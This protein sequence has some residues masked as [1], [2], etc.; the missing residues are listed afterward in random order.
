MKRFKPAIVF[1]LLVFCTGTS[2]S[3]RPAIL[4]KV[5][6]LHRV[7]STASQLSPFNQDVE[8]VYDSIQAANDHIARLLS[9]ILSTPGIT[10]YD[11]DS[12]LDHPFLSIVKS[13]DK[14]VWIFNWYEIT[15]GSCSSNLSIIHYRT[16]SMMPKVGHSHDAGEME[17]AGDGFCANGASFN[18]VYKLPANGKDLYLCLGSGR[19]CNTCVYEIA[20]V[21][22]LTKDSIHF[23][24]PAFRYTAIDGTGKKEIAPCFILEAR[25]DNIEEFDYDAKTR[26]L[27]FKYITDDN[28]PV[29]SNV[30]KKIIRK[31]VFNEQRFVG[32]PYR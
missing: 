27:R 16:R 22:E 11:L 19:S 20:S 24:Y 9:E 18:R 15:V 25:W 2:F 31:L 21:V 10:K 3:Q 26:T 1:L 28:T 17:G 5:D 23:N 14:R 30:K 13:A 29:Q 32:D 4:E 6:S 8:N 7:L 12:L